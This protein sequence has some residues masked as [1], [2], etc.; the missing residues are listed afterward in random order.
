[1]PDNEPKMWMRQVV[2]HLV[3]GEDVVFAC[4]RY[5]IVD[6]DKK[7]AKRFRDFI[8]RAARWKFGGHRR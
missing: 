8:R 7:C 4:S 6:R 3:D 1:M 5:L 2:R